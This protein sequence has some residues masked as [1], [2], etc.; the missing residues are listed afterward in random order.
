GS[1]PRTISAWIKTTSP[2]LEDTAIF[3]YGAK[4]PVPTTQ[5]FWVALRP[6]GRVYVA[7]PANWSPGVV[8]KSRVDDGSWHLVTA[9]YEGVSTNV[10]R[11][12]ID[13]K[14]DQWQ[15]LE[16]VPAT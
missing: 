15:K 13:G 7:A 8:G 5:R 16:V 9:V 1:E 10:V 14:P 4:T 6:D 2:Q 12:Y 11:I 3:D